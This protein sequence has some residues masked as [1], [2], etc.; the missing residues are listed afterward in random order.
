[1]G[2]YLISGFLIVPMIVRIHILSGGVFFESSLRYSF[3]IFTILTLMAA[4]IGEL[5]QRFLSRISRAGILIFLVALA[6][7][8]FAL[9]MQAVTFYAIERYAP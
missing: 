9:Q 4:H 5:S 3:I 2:I 7:G 8:S 1:M 6:A